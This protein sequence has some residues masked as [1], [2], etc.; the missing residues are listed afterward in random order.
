MHPHG[1]RRT[2][3]SKDVPSLASR[4]LRRTKIAMITLQ[5]AAQIV[6]GTPSVTERVSSAAF[7]ASASVWLGD[8]TSRQVRPR[9]LKSR[10]TGGTPGIDAGA[11]A[12]EVNSTEPPPSGEA[13]LTAPPRA[14]MCMRT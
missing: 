12:G 4:R 1:A 9:Q 3:A 11:P 8:T 13:S 14:K 5:M 2:Y 10:V 6:L 7:V